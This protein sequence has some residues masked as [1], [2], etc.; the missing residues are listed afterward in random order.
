VCGSSHSTEDVLKEMDTL[1][2]A[3]AMCTLADSVL[4]SVHMCTV[5]D[6]VLG[7]VHSKAD[8]RVQKWLQNVC[9][10]RPEREVQNAKW[11]S[12]AS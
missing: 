10:V 12:A 5:A 6:S 4:G 9:Y 8:T 2:C 11:P 7:S 3:G 1:C